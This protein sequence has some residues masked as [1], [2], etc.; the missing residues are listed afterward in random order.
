MIMVKAERFT[1]N[2]EKTKEKCQPDN[3]LNQLS[4]ILPHLQTQQVVTTF[5]KQMCCTVFAPF[6]L[7]VDYNTTMIILILT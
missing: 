4:M 1:S 3:K 6:V 2:K 5:F 7:N